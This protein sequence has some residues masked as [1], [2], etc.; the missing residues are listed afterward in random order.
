M[1]VRGGCFAARRT[2]S[3]REAAE[4]GKQ[5][6]RLPR[7]GLELSAAKRR[8]VLRLYILD[9]AAKAPAESASIDLIR[10]LRSP[11]SASIIRRL[12]TMA[13]CGIR[14]ADLERR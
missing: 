10:N 12:R 2:D 11:A 4:L 8:Q 7:H 14:G 9:V 13:G 3:V 5:I 6:R 1:S